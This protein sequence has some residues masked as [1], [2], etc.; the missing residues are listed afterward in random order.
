MTHMPTW[1]SRVV[2]WSLL[3]VTLT[4]LY[5]LVIAPVMADY[6]EVEQRSSKVRGQLARFTAIAA[7]KPAYEK[8]LADLDQ[9][10]AGQGLTVAGKTDSIATA[11]L[12]DRLRV[13]V[14][15]AG[16]SLSTLQS[17]A[18]QPEGRFRRIGLRLQARLTMGQL[19]EVLHQLEGGRPL[20]FIDNLEIKAR[21]KRQEGGQDAPDDPELTMRFDAYGYL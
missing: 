14:A 19:T 10:M 3:L 21:A 1:L 11:K 9:R 15:A 7:T 2:A 13:A 8:Q 12:Q 17:L 18:V 5:R 20:I 16:G 6:T 4:G